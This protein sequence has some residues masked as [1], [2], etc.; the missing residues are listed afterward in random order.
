MPEGFQEIRDWFS[1]ENQGAGVA[2]TNFGDGRQHVVVLMVDNPPQ[3]NRGLYRIGRNL[4][5]DGRVTGGWT[6]WFDVP[7]WFSWENQGADIAVADLSG[8]G[9]RD[10]I[11][12]MID[13]PP[14]KNQGKYRIGKK[15][16]ADGN[17]AEWT[18]WIDVPNWF[19]WENQGGGIAVTLPDGQGQRNLVVF[20]IDNPPGKNKGFYRV[21]KGL[22]ANGN[23]TGGWTNWIEV[24]DWFSFEN[25]GGSIAVA[26]FDGDGSQDLVVFMIDNVIQAGGNS[27]QNQGY[28]KVGR[29]LGADGKAATWDKNWLPLP[30]WFSWENQGGGIDIATVQD[31][32]KIFSLIVDNPPGKN[33]G[34]YQVVD[35]NFDPKIV[36]RWEPVFKLNNV[37]IHV[38]VLPN[39]K[40]LFWGRTDEEGDQRALDPHV[41]TPWV[42]DPKTGQ[43]NK[44]NPEHPKLNGKDFD[45][46]DTANLFCAGHAFMPDGRLFV[47]GGHLGDTDG[48]PQAST[49]DYRTNSWEP[50]KEMELGRWYPTVTALADGRMLVSAVGI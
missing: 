17:I 22:D 6:Q 42:W 44:T 41:C 38:S 34:L 40:V 5:A 9:N 7:N 26:D 23:V 47:A 27:G 3:Q 30:C 8:N 39:G 12:F 13:N 10:L 36:G 43:Q 25:Q 1:F 48:S 21:G 2:V 20:M 24:P 28:Y 32:K 49:Y 46:H 35:I 19:S 33:E 45:D 4:D 15:L 16:D 29:K 50:V 11:V 31:K 37:T 18:P 14:E